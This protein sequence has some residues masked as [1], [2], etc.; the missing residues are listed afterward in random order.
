MEHCDIKILCAKYCVHCCVLRLISSQDLCMRTALVYPLDLF[1]L[2]VCIW[3]YIYKNFRLICWGGEI[4]RCQ[5]QPKQTKPKGFWVPLRSMKIDWTVRLACLWAF[6]GLILMIQTVHIYFIIHRGHQPR[7]KSSWLD[8]VRYDFRMHLDHLDCACEG[9]IRSW[10]GFN[11][12]S[13]FVRTYAV[14]SDV[15][16]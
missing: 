6:F 9:L 8:I 14:I 12:G 11:V 10:L 2:F 1:H 3:I 13:G 16:I 7:Q 4:K 5:T 15:N